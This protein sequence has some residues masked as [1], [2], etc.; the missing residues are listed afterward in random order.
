MIFPAPPIRTAFPQ[1]GDTSMVSR[2]WLQWFQAITNQFS[3]KPQI[4]TGSRG[5]NAALGS[6]IQALA[7]AG[8]ITDNTTP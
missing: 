2:P 3:A 4:V 8:I 5:G 7:A 1:E 6:L